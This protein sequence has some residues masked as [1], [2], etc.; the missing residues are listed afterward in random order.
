VSS[1]RR[2][3]LVSLLGGTSVALSLLHVEAPFPLL[4]YLKFDAAEIPDALAFY[5][6]GPLYGVAAAALHT[7]GLLLRGSEPLGA[8]M[9]FLAVASMLAGAS[10]ARRLRWQ[11]VY[12]AAVRALAMSAANYVYLYVLFPGFLEYAASI[13]SW[14]GGVAALFLLTA[15]FNVVH[16]AATLAVARWVADAV[17]RRLGGILYTWS[18]A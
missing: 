10:L 16:A 7:V 9:K 18:G 4:P 14:L 2:A 12:G 6:C 11:I 15:L 17:G 5:L 3:V 8:L 13:V 1:Y